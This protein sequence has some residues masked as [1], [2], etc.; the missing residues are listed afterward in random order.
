VTHEDID[1]SDIQVIC[2]SGSIEVL[3]D[4]R[5]W[6]SW[7]RRNRWTLSAGQR[8]NQTVNVDSSWNDGDHRLRLLATANGTIGSVDFDSTDT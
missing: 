8:I 4:E 7:R 5:I 6:W 3:L 1:T 2:G